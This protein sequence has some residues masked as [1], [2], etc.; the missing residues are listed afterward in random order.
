MKTL[1]QV[2]IA[3]E[4]MMEATKWSVMK[5][6]REKKRVRRAADQANAALDG[7]SAEVKQRWPENLSMAYR[8]LAP[9]SAAVKANGHVLPMPSS[10][11]SP[12]LSAIARRV[13]TADEEAHRARMLAEKTFDEAEKRLSTS[14]ARQGC[15]QAIQSW[16][17][18]EKAIREA[19]SGLR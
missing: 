6:L 9:E 15:V 17:L 3:K 2:E 11:G 18:H 16:E 13:K 7:L 12:S 4:L 10:T 19:E 8:S 1:P 14:L 5:W